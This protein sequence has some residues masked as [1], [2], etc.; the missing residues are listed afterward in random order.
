MQEYLVKEALI[1]TSAL[2]IYHRSNY[3]HDIQN[4]HMSYL[5][6]ALWLFRAACQ[7]SFPVIDI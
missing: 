7:L 3:V 6:V 2:F 4:I 1:I 5:Y